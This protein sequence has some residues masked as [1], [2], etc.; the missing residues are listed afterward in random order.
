MSSLVCVRLRKAYLNYA[1]CNDM[2]D[3]LIVGKIIQVIDGKN[4]IVIGRYSTNK[5][6]LKK[7]LND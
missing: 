7:V 2:I 6:K 4:E 3:L 1:A 5:R